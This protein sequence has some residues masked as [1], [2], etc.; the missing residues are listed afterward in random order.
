MRKADNSNWQSI[1]SGMGIMLA[2]CAALVPPAVYLVFAITNERSEIHI[3][4][5]INSRL[6]SALINK[7]PKFWKFE[8]LRFEEI[9]SRRPGDGN[10][11]EYRQL[12]DLDKK[13]IAESKDDIQPPFIVEAASVFDAGHAVGAISITRSLRPVLVSA[14]V[15]MIISG[16]F[17][18]GVIFVLRYLPLRILRAVFSQLQEEKERAT[19]TL[20]SI[21]DAVVTF[22]AHGRIKSFNPIMEELSGWK[23]EEAMGRSWHEVLKL[24]HE[25]NREQI[26]DPVANCLQSNRVIELAANT[27]LI[28]K[29]DSK[30]YHVDVSVAPIRDEKENILGA[31]AILNDITDRKKSEKNLNYLAYHDHLTGLP[32][33]AQFTERLESIIAHARNHKKKVAVLYMDIDRFKI[34]N[35]S[36]GHI[37]GDRL[38]QAI[39]KQ[40]SANVRTDDIVARLGGDEFAIILGGQNFPEDAALVARKVMDAITPP[41]RLGDRKIHITGSIGISNFPDDADSAEE[42]LRNADIAM[43]RAKDDGRNK[44]QFYTQEL[45][46]KMLERLAL[47]NALHQAIERNEFRLVYQPILEFEQN[48]IVGVE[49]LLRW[50]SPTLGNKMPNIFIPVL[51]DTGLIEHVTKW[52]IQTA[53]TQAKKWLDANLPMKVAINISSRDFLEN[54][55]VSTITDVLKQTGLPPQYLEVEIT[56]NLL[57]ND[58]KK[59]LECF[60]A[61][62]SLGVRI[63]LDDF[64]TG[65]SSL[66]Y[67]K[68]YPINVLKIDKAFINDLNQT[69]DSG[70][71]AQAIISMAHILKMN[72]VAEGVETAQQAE[73]LNQLGCDEMQGYLLARPMSADALE[74]WLQERSNKNEL[75]K[76][77]G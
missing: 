33:R 34:V 76:A 71:I 52:V 61:I 35:D 25:D 64:G 4:A 26:A 50:E 54:N 69:T 15:V 5:E 9:L 2:L 8:S 21:A 60:L 11:K 74:K 1:I 53:V 42:L 27:V 72:V 32:N 17:G 6:V 12:F 48:S 62:S 46:E 36:L 51:E 73:I 24:I 56:E 58:P 66:S 10:N 47:E 45:N 37:V 18:A 29:T 16:F 70:A 19:V 22:D 43:Y 59:A 49:A 77:V 39:T 3:E 13:I 68:R 63:S 14:I 30:E 23:L 41:F 75:H 67:L 28:R 44:Y 7:N 20:N 55:V 57:L 38:L 31:V 65:Y 40:I